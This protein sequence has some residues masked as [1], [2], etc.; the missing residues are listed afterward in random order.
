MAQ[1]KPG[2]E[3]QFE[4]KLVAWPPAGVPENLSVSPSYVSK[5][6]FI[7]VAPGYGK[8]GAFG[9]GPIVVSSPEDFV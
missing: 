4:H 8:P 1:I 9:R 6:K 2:A 7:C 5:N 3:V